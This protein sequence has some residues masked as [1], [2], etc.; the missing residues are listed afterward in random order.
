MKFV[1]KS[2]LDNLLDSLRQISHLCMNQK[3]RFI[4]LWF[5]IGLDIPMVLVVCDSN[6]NLSSAQISYLKQ[7]K[8][9]AVE[10][11]RRCYTKAY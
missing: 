7:K 6:T 10:Y 3:K 1:R 5:E 4:L 9:V 2:I 8:N 11:S